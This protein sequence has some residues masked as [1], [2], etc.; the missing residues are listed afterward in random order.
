MF[1]K[2]LKQD[3]KVHTNEKKEKKGTADFR[4]DFYIG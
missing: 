1:D 2:G 4:V 3:R